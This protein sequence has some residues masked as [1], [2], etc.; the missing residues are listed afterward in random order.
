MLNAL[1]IGEFNEKR[2]V[3]LTR[4]NYINFNAK[5]R[6]KHMPTHYSIRHGA[7]PFI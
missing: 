2:T 5:Q 4:L 7:E 6:K 1:C 3:L